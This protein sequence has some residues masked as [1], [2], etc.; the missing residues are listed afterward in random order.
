[1]LDGLIAKIAVSVQADQ[2]LRGI[3]HADEFAI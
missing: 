1:M 2:W 3:S